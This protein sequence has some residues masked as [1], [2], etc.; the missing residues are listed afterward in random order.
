MRYLAR[1]GL[2]LLVGLFGSPMSAQSA[3]NVV[4]FLKMNLFTRQQTFNL[5]AFYLSSVQH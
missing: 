3:D 4:F 2:T 5:Q 1:L